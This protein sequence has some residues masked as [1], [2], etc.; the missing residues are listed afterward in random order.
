MD[1]PQTYQPPRA[2]FL[3][4]TAIIIL[5]CAGLYAV[6]HPANGATKIPPLELLPPLFAMV[7]LVAVVWTSMAL[8]RNLAVMRGIASVDYYRTYRQDPP[9][10]WTERPAQVF[11]NLMQVPQ[12][13]YLACVLMMVLER[14]DS[15]QLLLC[16]IFVALRMVHA[17]ILLIWN[18]V[19]YRF[20]AYACSCI[21]L[22]VLWWRIAVD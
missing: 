22:W 19:P 3:R 10:A 16:W 9:P 6:V 11:N 17:L 12:L 4:V 18:Y 15:V 7:G 21:T 20:A 8:V 13:F 5:V 2:D 14:A 1:E